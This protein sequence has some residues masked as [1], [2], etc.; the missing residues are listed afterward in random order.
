MNFVSVALPPPPPSVSLFPQHQSTTYLDKSRDERSI[1]N[2]LLV[3]VTKYSTNVNVPLNMRDWDVRRD[4]RE[5]DDRN[6][7]TF[8]E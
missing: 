3:F 6:E 1:A 2:C 7:I 5:R 4:R 8:W